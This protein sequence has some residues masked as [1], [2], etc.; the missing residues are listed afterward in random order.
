MKIL[1]FGSLNIDLVYQVDHIVQ[2]GETIA[3]TSHQI[4]AGGKGA[5]QSA[6]LAQADALVYHAGQIGKDGQLL[7]DKLKNLGVDMQFTKTVDG[8]TGHALIQVE[9]SGQNSIVL[10]PGVNTTLSR[11]YIDSV[12]DAFAIGDI[13]LLQNETNEIPYL[14]DQA[15]QRGMRTALNPAPF[16]TAVLNYPL[17]GVEFLIVNEKEAEGLVSL[18]ATDDLT[19]ALAQRLPNAQIILTLGEKGVHYRSPERQIHVEALRVEA[20]DTTAAGDT[21]TGYFLAA[22]AD[23]KPVEEALLRATH[24]AALCVRQPGAMDSIPPKKYVDKSLQEKGLTNGI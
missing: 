9:K 14:I 10:Y 15:A 12:L 24:A 19:S 4:Y 22:I 5:N 21:F 18:S 1:N 6:A 16:N 20:V 17:E 23:D 8:H 2:P 3:S 13:L 11:P 7:A